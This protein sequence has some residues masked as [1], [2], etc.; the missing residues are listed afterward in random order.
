MALFDLKWFPSQVLRLEVE[1]QAGDFTAEN[2][3]LYA[4]NGTV[5]VQLP[6]P[7]A[8]FQCVIKDLSGDIA[9]NPISIVRNGVENIDGQ[10]SNVSL[11]SNYQSITLISDGTDW[12]I[13]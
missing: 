6:A 12:F 3:K 9:N 2:G 7:A 1:A 10:A 8:N 4:V 13:Y 5:N 11:D